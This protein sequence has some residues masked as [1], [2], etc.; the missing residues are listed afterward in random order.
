[1]VREHRSRIFRTLYRREL[2]EAIHRVW[3]LDNGAERHELVLRMLD[4]APPHPGHYLKR[5][6]WITPG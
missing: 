1:M 4:P 2:R 5:W 6:T 3:Y